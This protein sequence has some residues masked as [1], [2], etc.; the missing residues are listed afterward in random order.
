MRL[1]K[2][3]QLSRNYDN[4]PHRSNFSK[5]SSE[6]HFHSYY[7]ANNKKF[8]LGDEMEDLPSEGLIGR[9]QKYD[10]LLFNNT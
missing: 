2:N 1:N 3:Q 5:A 8:F 10:V 7:E 4:H 9:I 6:K